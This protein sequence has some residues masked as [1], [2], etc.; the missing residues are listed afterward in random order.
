MA[1][2]N[3]W[4]KVFQLVLQ[5]T[6]GASLRWILCEILIKNYR[7]RQVS[8][9]F[10]KTRQSITFWRTHSRACGPLK[11]LKSGVRARLCGLN[12]SR[13]MMTNDCVNH[14]TDR[15]AWIIKHNLSRGH[16]T[17]WT[18]REPNGRL[19]RRNKFFSTN[20]TN[21]GVLGGSRQFP[22]LAI[23]HRS[24]VSR[25]F[26]NPTAITRPLRHLSHVPMCHILC[27]IK[28]W[29]YSVPND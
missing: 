9:K 28:N 29:K 4:R 11:N 25:E 24:R 5:R 23:I 2:V 22:N 21:L 7:P 18:P 10:N 1:F 6:R 15:T 26:G 8:L 17:R 16:C 20:S 19:H 12:A 13:V 27:N 14:V 3:P